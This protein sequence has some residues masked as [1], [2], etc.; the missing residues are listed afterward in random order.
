MAH[1]YV[2]STLS[3]AVLYQLRSGKVVIAGGTGVYARQRLYMPEGVATRITEDQRDEL[4]KIKSVQ[5]K[6]KKGYLKFDNR[7][8]HDE[9]I[10]ANLEKKD[11][12][13]QKT[14][15][16]ITEMTGAKPKD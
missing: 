7:L 2:Y 14:K 11:K 1:T 13:A 6:I 9:D 8:L 4:L 5:S 12:S 10:G 16:E 15:K 3:N